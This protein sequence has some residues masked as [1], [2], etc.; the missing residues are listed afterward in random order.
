MK[1]IFLFALISCY[2]ILSANVIYVSPGGTGDG[3][4]WQNS[5]D[6]TTLPWL[7][8]TD[9][10]W[11][12]QGTYIPH[13]TDQSKKFYF[14]Q[15]NFYGGFSGVETML[16]Q[17][18]Y[19]N[20]KTYLSGDINAPGFHEDNSDLVLFMSAN[21]VLDG[22][23][24]VGGGD[25][26]F[27][28]ITDGNIGT[29]KINNCDF[30]G[31]S[32]PGEYG[33]KNTGIAGELELENCVFHDF[34]FSTLNFGTALHSN[35]ITRITACEF[36]NI[37]NAS[38]VIRIHKNPFS[39]YNTFIIK[40]KITNCAIAA[41]YGLIAHLNDTRHT[42]MLSGCEVTGNSGASS[43]FGAAKDQNWSSG[44]LLIYS[45][46]I[47]GN[48]FLR[49]LV[50]KH[51]GFGSLKISKSQIINNI[52]A[53]DVDKYDANIGSF[54]YVNQI[55]SPESITIE[56]ST[57][58]NNER[59]NGSVFASFIQSNIS[60]SLI[61]ENS[62]FESNT[63]ST[64]FIEGD[65]GGRIEKSKFINNTARD[66][67]LKMYSIHCN[68]SLFVKNTIDNGGFGAFYSELNYNFDKSS[69][70]NCTFADNI[71]TKPAFYFYEGR[72]N[73][74]EFRNC[75]IT[76]NSGGNIDVREHFTPTWSIAYSITD[77]SVMFK[78]TSA[79]NYQLSLT[80]P[81]ID[82][83]NS[84]WAG[85]NDIEGH[86]WK[87]ISTVVNTGAGTPDYTDIGAFE[88]L[89]CSNSVSTAIDVVCEGDTLVFG[90]QKLFAAGDYTEVFESYQGCDS[91]VT[92][93][94]S[95]NDTFNLTSSETVCFGESYV[96]GF[97]TLNSSGEYKETFQTISGCDSTVT[98]DF[99][100]KEEKKSILDET[101]CSGESYV[102]GTQTI[103]TSGQFIEIFQV[104]DCD[105]AVT[106]NLTVASNY[107]DQVS[108][109]ICTGSNYAFGSQTVS[110]AGFYQET[111]SSISGCDSIVT[112][113]VSMIS[114]K[115]G[116]ETASICNGETYTFG[117]QTLTSAGQ[118]HETFEATNGCDSIVT[119]D[120]SVT[121]IDKTIS[122]SN[123]EVE[124]TSNE[125]GASYQWINCFIDMDVQGETSQMF[126]ANLNGSYAVEVTKES[127]IDTSACETIL[128]VG[129]ES[130][131]SNGVRIYPNPSFGQIT[132]EGEFS[133]GKLMS[134]N[135]TLISAFKNS[136]GSIEIS[137]LAK[138]IY[139]IKLYKNNKYLG[140][141][142]LVVS[143]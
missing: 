118:F 90:T 22:F 130:L 2:S 86:S 3:S 65:K 94:L 109:D 4:S 38:G 18:D 26:Q 128:S 115:T 77:N 73:A 58:E 104:G 25:D 57:F 91:S 114:P 7:T 55:R 6:L 129:I 24:F 110:S 45:S 74:T 54:I 133:N 123:D 92:I 71:C 21:T 83:G 10:V 122:I 80:S 140:T 95:L 89:E 98:L 39:A 34:N 111:F 88:S 61:I 68:R 138:G 105:S 66:Q 30:D 28:E 40:T 44:S 78:D 23:Y 87:D 143:K 9:S 43:I 62:T 106:L 56:S 12:K 42:M 50:E 102:L 1:K 134:L 81:G 14:L 126:T 124:L 125:V 60:D 107:N 139:F 113:T 103:S 64:S 53:A 85:S 75:I 48:S 108:V 141:Q 20:N 142:K 47:S 51:G 70:Y 72:S 99:I 63:G 76:N 52:Y 16:D 137:N 120:L 136:N 135:G 121:T 84:Y 79:N 41:G 82:A 31:S 93:T 32:N 112:L 46:L 119:L 29:I 100:V 67:F 33:V 127:C 15:S 27:I 11:V 37:T 69:F 19:I 59:F 36:D 35:T 8:P 17:R 131:A 117:T 13:A 5:T 132:I 101:I 97:Q 116:S 96:F 49:G